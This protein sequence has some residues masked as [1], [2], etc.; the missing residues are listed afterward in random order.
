MIKEK[1]TMELRYII[2]FMLFLD[3]M[4]FIFGSIMWIIC[5]TNINNNKVLN[6]I[7]SIL[8]FIVITSIAWTFTL[9]NFHKNKNYTRVNMAILLITS[10]FGIP[11][12]QVMLWKM[13]HTNYKI[14]KENIKLHI[15]KIITSE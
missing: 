8:E 11:I 4:L 2:Y 3:F 1:P 9:L 12:L 15:K 7:F 14:T 13:H 5:I 10:L 6:I